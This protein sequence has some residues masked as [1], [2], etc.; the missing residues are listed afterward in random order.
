MLEAV[1]VI[2]AVARQSKTAP[3]GKLVAPKT[4]FATDK[5]VIIRNPSMAGLRSETNSIPYS[6]VN[7]VKLE[8]GV[9]TSKVKISSGYFNKDKEG[10]IDAIPKEKAARIVAVINEGIRNAQFQTTQTGQNTQDPLTILKIRLAKGEI[11]KKE[12]DELKKEFE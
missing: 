10:Y 9:F 5:R 11:T 7:N 12:Y 4:I 2:K 3:G 6:Q 1:E 8:K